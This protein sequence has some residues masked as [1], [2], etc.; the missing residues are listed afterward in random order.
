M[1]ALRQMPAGKK[2]KIKVLVLR[3][4]LS[5]NPHVR[6]AMRHACGPYMAPCGTY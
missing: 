4:F 2:K 5:I 6:Y 3:T 1:K